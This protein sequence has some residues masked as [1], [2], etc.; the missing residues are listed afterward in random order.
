MCPVYFVWL[1]LNGVME[2]HVHRKATFFRPLVSSYRSS[3]DISVRLSIRDCREGC[4]HGKAIVQTR[5]SRSEFR[6]DEAII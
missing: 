3:N 2:L 1:A 5:L 6:K 4:V